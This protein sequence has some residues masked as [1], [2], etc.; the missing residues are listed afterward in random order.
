AGDET[1]HLR[2]TFLPDGRHFL[3]RA[4]IGSTGSG[5]IYVGSLDSMERRVLMQNADAGNLVYALGHLMFMRETTLMAQPFDARRFELAG[6]PFPVADGLQTNQS[7]FPVGVFAA[8]DS[9]VLA[10]QT[11]S[12]SYGSQLSW[13]DRSGK[14][15]E[16]VADRAPYSDVELSPDGA[17]VAV[18][19]SAPQ[20][21]RDIWLVDVRRG[22]R[23]RF[24]F[25]PGTKQAP[26]WAP[27][28]SRLVFNSNRAG[29]A[30]LFQKSLTGAGN[31]EPL[32][33]DSDNKIPWSWSPD[34]RYIAYQTGR[35]PIR[36][37]WVLPVRG[38]RKPLP[39]VQTPAV[40][41]QPRFSPDGRWL[42]YT[43]AEPSGAQ[44]Y[45][46]PFP[47]PGPQVQVSSHGGA[48]PRWR[49]DGREMFY[50]QGRTLMAAAV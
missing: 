22:V 23:S 41:S 21:T 7:V 8:S 3:Y 1:L 46:V 19:V 17:Q 28:G 40:K 13:F 9:G 38:D 4:N 2:P 6:D 15:V 50:V 44:V 33:S 20:L 25:D 14:L 11:G 18:S 37:I 31:V 24:T 34:G 32:L 12:A 26:I 48:E 47:G 30:D 29:H 27:D 35:A 16:S 42:A 36:D 45:V 43:S 49:R 5:H 10:Y 39:I